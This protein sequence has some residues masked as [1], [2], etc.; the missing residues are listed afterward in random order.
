MSRLPFEVRRQT[1]DSTAFERRVAKVTGDVADRQEAKRSELARAYGAS[2]QKI[3]FGKKP[4]E[5]KGW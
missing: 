4:N 2:E 1:Q 5:A 3:A